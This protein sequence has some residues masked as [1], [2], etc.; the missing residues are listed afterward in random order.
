MEHIIVVLF[1]YNFIELPGSNK[2]L[3][4]KQG[5][6]HSPGHIKQGEKNMLHNA[7]PVRI[8]QSVRINIKNNVTV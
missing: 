5:L 8:S 6:F 1:Y 2:H 4:E 7:L 3:G